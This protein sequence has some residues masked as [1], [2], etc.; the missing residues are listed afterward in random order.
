MEKTFTKEYRVTHTDTDFSGKIN[1]A[2]LGHYVLDIAGMHAIEIKTSMDILNS[3]NLTWVVSGMHFDIIKEL[4]AINSIIKITTK[5]SEISR[6]S[7]KRDFYIEHNGEI[8]AEISTEWLIINVKTRRPVFLT[9]VLPHI[10]NLIT[11][12]SNVQ[13]YKHLRFAIEQPDQAHEY[14]I[15]YSDIDINRHLYSIRYLE[16][17]LN[18]VEIATFEHRRLVSADLN[19]MS[20]VLYNQTVKT[21]IKHDGDTDLVEMQNSDSKPMFRA[22]FLWSDK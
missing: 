18:M 22:E 13:K 12:E 14:T 2:A 21:I 1:V 19:F 7:C 10:A 9:D 16:L 5:I 15:R 6:L 20:E 4:P 17:A 8:V 11:P 3:Q